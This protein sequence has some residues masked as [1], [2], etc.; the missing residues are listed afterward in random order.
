MEQKPKRRWSLLLLSF[1]AFALI[2]IAYVSINEALDPELAQRANETKK[3]F[4]ERKKVQELFDPSTPPPPIAGGSVSVPNAVNISDIG[5][6]FG[7]VPSDI[8]RSNE[9]KEE[10]A[11]RKSMEELFNPTTPVPAYKKETKQERAVRKSMEELFNP[12]TPVPAYKKETKQERAVRKSV[13]ELFDLT[14]S[15]NNNTDSKRGDQ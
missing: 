3:E 8:E 1:V 14:V 7:A 13:E 9:P 4:E 5:E 10:R 11:V 15:N 2:A 6:L 12:T